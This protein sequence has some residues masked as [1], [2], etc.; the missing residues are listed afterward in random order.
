MKRGA[1]GSA[2]KKAGIAVLILAAVG[3]VLFARPAYHWARD[4]YAAITRPSEE[5]IIAMLQRMAKR[6]NGETP[7]KVNEGTH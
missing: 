2:A 7:K 5:K 6:L 4:T 1:S 3:G